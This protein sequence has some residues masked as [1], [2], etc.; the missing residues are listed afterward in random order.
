[1]SDKVV[2]QN[3]RPTK[4]ITLPSFKDSKVEIYA[5]LLA[6]DLIGLDRSDDFSVGISSLAKFIKSWNFTDDA[7]VDLPITQESLMNFNSND[8]TALMEEIRSFTTEEKK[9]LPA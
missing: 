3:S 1:M 2:F 8:L 5:S 7:G 6:K 9:E 4:T